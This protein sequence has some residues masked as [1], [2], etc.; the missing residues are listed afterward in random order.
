MN[1]ARVGV[2]IYST[3]WYLAHGYDYDEAA[4]LLSDQGFTFV[5]AQNRYLP[6]ADSAVKSEVT[7]DQA[8][9]YQHYDDRDF[10]RAVQARGIEYWAACN[11]FFDT[12]TLAR[13]PGALPVDATGS[14][15]KM[16]DWYL[17]T[18]PTHEAYLLEKLGQLEEAARILQPDGVFLGFT[19]FPGFWELWLPGDKRSDFPEYCF[20]DRCVELFA[21]KTGTPVPYDAPA[22]RAAWIRREAYSDFVS[23]KGDVIRDVIARVRD[24][25]R[26]HQSGARIMLN[27]IPFRRDDFEGAGREVFAQDWR[28]LAEVVDVFELMTYHQ[29]LARDT[30][31][32]RS[33]AEDFAATV[34]R[35][36]VCTI[37]AEPLYLDGMHAGRGRSASIPVDEFARAVAA[38]R[39][40]PAE[41]VVVFTW[42]DFLRQVQTGDKRRIDVL[43][44]F[45]GVG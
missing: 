45:R 36:A 19:R 20:C 24:V 29:I 26:R 44:E 41:G 34:D 40:S 8:G 30:D 39:D 22:A 6:M 23:W 13:H 17:G 31:W 18:C 32:I 33:V 25:V 21:T 3:D 5:I 15:A 11:M 35:A 42:S 10:A 16:V 27:T 37:Q 28:K 43:R 2:K 1:R 38:V 12:D 4:E 14:P 7:V 9:R